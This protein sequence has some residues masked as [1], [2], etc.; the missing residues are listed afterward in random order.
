GGDVE[1]PAPA[2]GFGELEFE[3]ADVCVTSRAEVGFRPLQSVVPPYGIS[4]AFDQ[5]EKSLDDCLR[6]R[7]TGG[8]AVGI[9]VKRVAR[10]AI[11]KIQQTCRQI[12]EPLVAQRPDRRPFNLGRR[13]EREGYLTIVCLGALRLLTLRIAEQQ[14]VV[15]INGVALGKV[16]EPPRQPD[17]VA[18]KDS[19]I[20]LDRLHERAGLA[21]LGGTAL[22]EAAAAQSGP[23]LVDGPGL[24]GKTVGGEIIGVQGKVRVDPLE[25]RDHAGERAHV[26]AE[27][28]DRGARGNGAIPPAGHQELAALAKLDRRR[29]AVRIAQL[30]LA[31][32]RTLRTGRHVMARNGCAQ[33]VE[34]DDVIDEVGA[35]L[36]GDRFG[37]L[38]RS[39][40][41]AALSEHVAGERRGG[42]TPCRYSRDQRLDLAIALHPLAKAG[43]AGAVAGTQHRP[44][45]REDPR[46]LD[47]QPRRTVRQVLTV[48]V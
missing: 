16:R 42:E 3:V 32:D 14:D 44:D 39:Q 43:P 27:S 40:L 22:A 9:R 36:G 47:K 28:R 23:E 13:I 6:E 11:E 35:K 5:L 7:V 45:Q 25:T 15:G 30:L 46:R 2:S 18:L 4:I 24:R 31:A 26:L 38:D 33:Q 12:S 10:S 20:A 34:A 19:G 8:A 37:D 1:C 48:P 41:N 17:L 21:L 29:R